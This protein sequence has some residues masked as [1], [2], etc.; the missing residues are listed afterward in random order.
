M[1]IMSS[2]TKSSKTLNINKIF[3]SIFLVSS[4]MKLNLAT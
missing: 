1:R 2:L 4:D 3:L